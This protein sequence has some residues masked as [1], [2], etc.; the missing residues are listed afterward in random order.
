[1]KMNFGSKKPSTR[2]LNGVSKWCSNL[3]KTKG[4]WFLKWEIEPLK[5][6][7]IN[8]LLYHEVG[9]HVDWYNRIWSKANAKQ[10]EEFADQYAIQKTA[11]AT[12]VFNKLQKQNR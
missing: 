3:Q 10:L 9:H 2:F 6:Y 12:H 11:T 1:M 7:Y 8:H 5:E 4:K